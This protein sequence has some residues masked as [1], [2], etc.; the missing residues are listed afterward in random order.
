MQI[1]DLAEHSKPINFHDDWHVVL[2]ADYKE[3]GKMEFATNQN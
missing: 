3:K 2:Y 1:N